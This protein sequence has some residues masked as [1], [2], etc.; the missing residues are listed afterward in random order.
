MNIEL[1]AARRLRVS[2]KTL[3]PGEKVDLTVTPHQLRVLVSSGHKVSSP[4][5][6]LK[7]DLSEITQA[8]G[9]KVPEDAT[10]QDLKDALD[11]I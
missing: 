11:G 7:R 6:A 4:P 8:L 1:T 10:K 9:L 3:D 2:K 5:G